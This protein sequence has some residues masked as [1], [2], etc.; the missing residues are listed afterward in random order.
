MGKCSSYLLFKT[1]SDFASIG[2]SI[3]P[4]SSVFK[5]PWLRAGY[6][7]LDV[8]NELGIPTTGSPS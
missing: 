8:R 6:P 2:P 1:V 7:A 5:E 3:L 4:A